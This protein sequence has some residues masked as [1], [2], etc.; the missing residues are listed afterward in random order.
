[1]LLLRTV[2]L[3][4]IFSPARKPFFAL[5]ITGWL[6]WELWAA[7]Q[8]AI[9]EE[10]R[11]A[12]NPPLPGQMPRNGNRNAGNGNGNPALNAAPRLNGNREIPAD[13]NR[14]APRNAVDRLAGYH[15]ELE[16][17]VLD[18]PGNSPNT[19][20]PTVF[21]RLRQAF[22]LFILTVHPEVWNRR[23]RNL[24]EREARVKRELVER[25]RQRPGDGDG[26][27]PNHVDQAGQRENSIPLE[28]PRRK[29]PWLEEYIERVERGEWID[30]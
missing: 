1:M 7:A 3:L 6:V 29:A 26:E 4:Y 28:Q 25:R 15:L 9:A 5:L 8:G 17:A 27:Q 23:R 21:R 16:D 11:G 22:V 14:W 2:F 20:P 30:G 19:R 13:R 12:Q 24:R 10:R 18:A